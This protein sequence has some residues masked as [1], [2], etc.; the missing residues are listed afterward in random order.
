MAFDFRLK[1]Y[2]NPMR[3]DGVFVAEDRPIEPYSN[4]QGGFIRSLDG[5]PRYPAIPN[6]HSIGTQLPR[7]FAEELVRRWNAVAPDA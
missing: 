6:G 5:S 2:L 1:V 3:N 4:G 7:D